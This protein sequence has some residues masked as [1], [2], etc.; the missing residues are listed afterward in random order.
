VWVYLEPEAS[1]AVS[2]SSDDVTDST[3][4]QGEY[5]SE[6][7]PDVAMRIEDDVDARDSVDLDGDVDMVRD[8]DDE[9]EEDEEEDDKDEEDE[10]EKEEEEDEEDEDEDEDDGKEPRT[11]RQGEMVNSSADDV[12]TMVNDQRIVLPEQSQELRKHTPPP[13]PPAPAPRPQSPEPH[14]RS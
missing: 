8:G 2:M 12:D 3:E 6:H 11:I 1:P 10:K 4:L 7:D 14:P 9:E 13:Q 5:A